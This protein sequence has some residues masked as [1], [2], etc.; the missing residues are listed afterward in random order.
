MMSLRTFGPVSHGCVLTRLCST[1]KNPHEALAV[2]RLAPRPTDQTSVLLTKSR[3]KAHRILHE[4]VEGL[5]AY[6]E[7]LRLP[8]RRRWEVEAEIHVG[9]I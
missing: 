1:H 2:F 7:P 6:P 9:E 4:H 5:L 8:D 3:A